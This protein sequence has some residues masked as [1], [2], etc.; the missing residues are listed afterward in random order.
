MSSDEEKTLAQRK[1]KRKQKQQV[2]QA[3][4]AADAEFEEQNTEQRALESQIKNDSNIIDGLL[5]VTPE[6]S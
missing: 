4:Q 1:K 5:G 3:R 6:R 2:D